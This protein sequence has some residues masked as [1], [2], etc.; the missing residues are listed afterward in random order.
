MDHKESFHRGIFYM[1]LSATTLSVVGLLARLGMEELT[2]Q[3]LIFWRF[4][5]AFILFFLFLWIR[6][7]LKEKHSFGDLKL[8]FIRPIFTLGAQ[9]S[10]YYY[11]QKN[12]LLN[13]TALLNTG[14][15]FIP[16]IE[17]GVLGRRVGKSTW[18]GVAV[19]FAG[20]LCILQ[21]DAGIF[22]LL[23]LIGLLSGFSQGASQVVLSLGSKS[24]KPDLALLYLFFFCALFSLFPLLFT[25]EGFGVLKPEGSPLFILSLALGF[26]SIFN[27]T[28]RAA[29]YKHGSASR[30]SPFL[31]FSAIP[32]GIFDW[33]IF[34]NIP[35][36]LSLL[37]VILVIGGGML[38]YFLHMSHVRKNENK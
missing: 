16:L 34:G 31:Y 8:Q 35:N 9:Y 13:A 24:E 11:I 23:S 33:A 5:T 4:F 10:F 12:T 6:G 14:A 29:A 22:S 38:K 30:L 32:A 2:L 17:W 15:L 20:V 3:G 36:L 28:T 19:S 7:Q 25:G 18:I 37:G 21:P 1:L 26:V 27:Q